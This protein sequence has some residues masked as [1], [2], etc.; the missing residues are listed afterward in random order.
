[1]GENAAMAAELIRINLGCGRKYLDG[2]V[3][4]DVVSTV[5]ADRYFDL[6]KFP[7]PF[8]DGSAT[9]IL[10]DN[11]LEH[12]EDIPGTMTELH[13]ILA[14]GGTVLIKVPYG[15]S[16][17]ALQDPTHKH[18]FTERSMDYFTV[19]HEYSFYSEARFECLEARLVAD[20]TTLRH[21]MRNLIPFRSILRYFLF[22][23][24]D[25]VH[26]RLRKP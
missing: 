10:M 18:Y 17:W 3:N 12:L 5:R 2:W 7:Y 20:S 25:G 24:Y 9:E 11:V 16:D 26:F 1:M 4:C 19:G 21:V 13:R 23:L 8:E 6:E 22:N 15:K 14:P